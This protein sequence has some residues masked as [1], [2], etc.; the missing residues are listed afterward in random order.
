MRMGFAMVA[1]DSVNFGLSMLLRGSSRTESVLSAL[2]FFNSESLLPLRSNACLD[3]AAL[4]LDHL[5]PDSLLLLKAVNRP[6]AP[7]SA[8]GIAKMGAQ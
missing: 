3:P 2:D 7:S 4:L 8:F 5:Q 1:M 6:D